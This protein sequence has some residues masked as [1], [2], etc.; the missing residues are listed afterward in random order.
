MIYTYKTDKTTVNLT[1][2]DNLNMTKGT[3]FV[4]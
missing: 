4:F 1:T 2:I 3:L